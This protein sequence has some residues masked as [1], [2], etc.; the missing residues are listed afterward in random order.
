MF[1]DEIIKEF[2]NTVQNK[3]HYAVHGN[4][5]AEVIFNIVE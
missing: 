3:M 5:V 2:F 4:T 1:R